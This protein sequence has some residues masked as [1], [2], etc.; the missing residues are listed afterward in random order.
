M[1]LP[2][3]WTIALPT[4]GVG[5]RQDLPLPFSYA[6][7]GAAAALI[8]SFLALAAWWNT[9]RW[10]HD[11]AGR[12]LPQLL[13]FVANSPVTHRTLAGIGLI[14][15]GYVA[16]PL[17]FG[18]DNARNPMP[19]VIYVL[20]WV[21]LIPLSV[22]AG[23]IWR[24][25][26]PLRTIHGF[27]MVL[28]RHDRRHG[29]IPLP[30]AL[31]YW[32][33]ALGLFAFTWL[34]LVA[35]S[36]TTL[37]TLRLAVTGYVTI[38]LVAALIFGARW[39][40]RGDAFEVW[41]TLFGQL[42]MIGRRADGTATL[43]SPLVGLAQLPASPGLT[44]TVC[45]MVGGTAYD[46]ASNAP[47]WFAFAQSTRWPLA[48]ETLGL[49]SVIFLVGVVF[50]GF[51]HLA[52]RIARAPRI[53]VGVFAPS[54]VPVALGYAVAH[55]W[56]LFILEGQT[57]WIRLSD[58]LGNGGNWLGLSDRTPSS[59]LLDPT[60]VATVQ[61]SA[62]IIGHIMGVILAHEQAVRVFSRRRAV[63]GQIPLLILMLVYTC[64][65]LFALFA[66]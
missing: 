15:A 36:N 57:A 61:V 63:V 41:S 2:A 64:G 35:P 55:Y 12:P 29:V 32:P 11:A 10:T 7:I 17:I 28:A 44:A 27:I 30:P 16:V 48:I 22:V 59:T 13:T 39:F 19:F 66:A 52:A 21:G 65:G 43:R 45:V 47:A 9:P 53:P 14:A 42:S 49:L 20:L 24:R 60:L 6:V 1:A 18:Q 34:E 8:L 62:I 46:G 4:H 38:H 26:N 50:S 3:S 37:P 31:G 40:D 51:I 23:P 58:P 25:L 56:S 5:N 33:A 54:L